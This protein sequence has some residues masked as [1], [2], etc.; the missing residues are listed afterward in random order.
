MKNIFYFVFT[1]FFASVSLARWGKVSESPYILKLNEV[2][3]K[4]KANGA[5]ESKFYRL[6]EIKNEQG[7]NSQGLYKFNFNPEAEKL[8]SIE[9][10]TINGSK[11][12]EVPEA[13]IVIKPLSSS[14]PGFDTQ[15]QVSVAYPN[16]EIGSQLELKYHLVRTK[17]SL[18]G[19][20][21]DHFTIGR[22]VAIENYNEIWESEGP[23]YV[24]VFDPGKFLNVTKSKNK[25][26]VLLVKPIY[27]E[28]YEEKNS[29]Y[30]PES[31]TW[32][33]VTNIEKWSD[34]PKATITAYEDVIKSELP[35]SYKAI[36]EEAKKET[37]PYS[38]IDAVTSR[39]ADTLRYL[40]DWRLVKGA[41]HPRTLEVIS[42]SG[43]GDCK[44]M[45]VSTAAILT[46][47][48]F[49]A[50]AAFV[51]RNFDLI[52][53]P[54]KVP[55][56]YFNHAIVW[57]EKDGKE[58]WI[59]PTNHTSSARRI[60]PD[61]ADH[62]TVILA[63]EGARESKTPAGTPESNSIKIDLDIV[64]KNDSELTGKGRIN[65]AGFASESITGDELSSSKAQL[66]Y[67]LVTWATNL[68]DLTG[69]K[70]DNYNLRSRIV[71]D[72]SVGFNF[73]AGWQTLVSS[74]GKGYAVP[75]A[76]IVKVVN[77]SLTDRESSLLLAD[78]FEYRRSLRVSG[79]D[80]QNAG[81][82]NCE[83]KYKW[84]DYSRKIK[85]DDDA[86]ILQD[87][88]SIKMPIIPISDLKS[89]DFKKAQKLFVNCV[90]DFAFIFE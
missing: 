87:F 32:V 69:W 71:K 7:R 65:L 42:G 8:V 83:G 17:P 76:G 37:D 90:G 50:H 89:A 41:Y 1:V 59:D 62:K 61:I 64:F 53:S 63:P 13:D 82:L 77:T 56:V 52:A 55:A 46:R 85:E 31:L 58:Y 75:Q 9:A 84:F 80:M 57:A 70:F 26:E 48:G 88:F 39:L 74:A 15:N 47:M 73:Q 11:E 28:I 6:I 72:F 40:G 66:D 79:K 86:L 81:K 29:I 67:R 5:F 68:P 51:N 12:Y 38:Q 43:Y 3:N 19:Y 14:G 78:P 45:T 30:A 2:K 49:K 35:A 23:L 20:F 36:L 16:V 34:F 4:I 25:I 18:P 33:G 27:T 10:K 44:D 21:N 22:H 60:Y 24:E 54:I